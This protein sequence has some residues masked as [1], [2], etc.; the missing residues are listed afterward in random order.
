M[1]KYFMQEKIQICFCMDKNYKKIML[2][3]Q[4]FLLYYVINYYQY[5][6]MMI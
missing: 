6:D 1:M 4:A 2:I 3:Y 5:L